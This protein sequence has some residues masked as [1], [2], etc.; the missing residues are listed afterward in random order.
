MRAAR[1]SLRRAQSETAGQLASRSDARH[2]TTQLEEEAARA[3]SEVLQMSD[4]LTHRSLL[5][6]PEQA[7]GASLI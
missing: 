2:V 1:G 4:A 3:R 6:S 5:A 7:D